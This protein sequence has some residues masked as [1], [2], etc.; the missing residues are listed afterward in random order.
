MKHIF[1]LFYKKSGVTKHGT[2]QSISCSR[3][4]I[5]LISVQIYDGANLVVDSGNIFDLTYAGGKVGV[6]SDSQAGIIYSDISYS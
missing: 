3:P 1:S 2:F 6:Y 4:I 5:G